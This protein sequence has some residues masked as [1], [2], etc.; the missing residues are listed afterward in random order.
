VLLEAPTGSGKTLMAG[1]IAEAFSRADREDNARILWFWFT[2][3]RGLVEQARGALKQ[4]FAGLRIRDLQIDRIARNASSGDVFVTTW[5]A[6]AANSTE[7]RRVRRGGD[8]AVALDDFIGQLRQDGFRIG[9]VVD[10][11]HHTFF[12]SGTE[13]A[14]FYRRGA[15]S[16]LSP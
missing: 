5:A 15:L 13:A 3:Y 1:M 9:A 6:V 11:A 7:T 2:P 4:D 16:R 12:K 10:E 8:S 14:K